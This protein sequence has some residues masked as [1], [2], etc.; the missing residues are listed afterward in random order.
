VFAE[1]R[2]S[3][4]LP[5]RARALVLLIEPPTVRPITRTARQII[6]VSAGRPESTTC[7]VLEAAGDAMVD[8]VVVIEVD[9]PADVVT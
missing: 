2:S 8:E 9:Q 1:D 7:R 3:P 6:G 5:G 4:V